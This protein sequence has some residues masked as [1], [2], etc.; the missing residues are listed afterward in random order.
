MAATLLILVAIVIVCQAIFVRDLLGESAFWQTEFV[1]FALI[2]AT[3]IGAPYVLMTRGHVNVDLVPLLLGPRGRFILA[4]FAAAVG[5]LFCL[6][7]FLS[8]LDWWY[9]AYA[10]GRVTSSMWRARLWIPYLAV[11]VGSALLCLQYVAD[12]WALASG[13]ERPFGLKPRDRS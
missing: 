11:P 6:V 9:T 8:S 4:L 12:L 13:R 2:G 5:L 1:T 10:G 3:F 7:V